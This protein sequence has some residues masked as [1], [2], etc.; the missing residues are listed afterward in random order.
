[1]SE[2]ERQRIIKSIRKSAKK[3]ASN[4]AES[5]AFLKRVGI[6]TKAGKISKWYA[7]LI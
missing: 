7:K 3:Y 4:K 5:I 6:L 2:R 1:M